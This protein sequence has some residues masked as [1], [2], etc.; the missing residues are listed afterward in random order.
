MHLGVLIRRVGL[1][2]EVGLGWAG[3][4]QG[5]GSPEWSFAEGMS[6][7]RRLA[8][9]V[10]WDSSACVPGGSLSDTK[11]LSAVRVVVRSGDDT[12]SRRQGRGARFS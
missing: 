7:S 12:Q 10:Y 4:V 6:G 5:A 2:G 11:E 1:L 8:D 3:A 9:W